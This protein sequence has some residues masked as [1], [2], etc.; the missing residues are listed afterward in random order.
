M[1]RDNGPPSPRAP[2]PAPRAPRPAPR[3]PRLHGSR[4]RAGPPL[5][6]CGAAAGR[7]ACGGLA[8]I[9]IYSTGG[10]TAD[11]GDLVRTIIVDSTVRHSAPPG[12]GAALSRPPTGG[13]RRSRAA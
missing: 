6:R 11:V 12:A 5:R 2:R 3:A 1:L 8:G 4:P 13:A 10:E 7:R 9:S